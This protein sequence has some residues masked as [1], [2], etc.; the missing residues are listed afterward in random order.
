MQ[1]KIIIRERTVPFD[2]ALEEAESHLPVETFNDADTIIRNLASSKSI[3]ILPPQVDEFNQK[4]AA[5]LF[6]EKIREQ[7]SRAFVVAIDR[8]DF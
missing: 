1:P 8:V 4:I 7:D 6:A 5:N 3:Y 2:L